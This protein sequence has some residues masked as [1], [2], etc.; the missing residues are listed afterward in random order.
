MLLNDLNGLGRIEVTTIP[1]PDSV[2]VLTAAYTYSGSVLVTCRRKEDPDEADYYTLAVMN[3]D[4]TGFHVIFSGQIPQKKGA[5]GIRFMPFADKTRVLLG[6][7]VLECSPDIDSCMK[8]SLIPLEYP[9]GIAE[10]PKTM[11]HWSEIIIAPDNQHI[12]WTS[13]RSDNGAAAFTGKLVRKEDRYIIEKT[14]LISSGCFLKEEGGYLIPQPIRGGEVKQFVRGGTAISSVGAK[15]GSLA[16]SVIQELLSEEVAQITHTPGYDE[17][18]MLSPDE[19]LGL[20]MSAR[21]SKGTSCAVFG[22]LPKPYGAYTSP[23][24]IMPVYMYC[25]AGVRAFRR[26]NIGPILIDINRS[27][28]ERDYMGV[29]LCDPEEK[30]VY[31]SPMSWHPDSKRVMWPEILRESLSDEK[32]APLRIRMA[33]LLDYVPADTVPA[34]GTPDIIPYAGTYEDYKALSNQEVTGRIQGKSCGYMEVSQKGSSMAGGSAET[35]Y[36]NFSDDGKTFWN[37]KEELTYGYQKE[38]VYRADLELSGREQGEMKLQA[39]FSAMGQGPV[40]LLFDPDENGKPKS[41]GYSSYRGI[42]WKI[43]DM[44]K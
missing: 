34:A 13:L 25:V 22:L 20:V 7:Y 30:W 33:R 42:T 24:L 6:D 31:C 12:S 14:N 2:T 29:N 18:T 43:E 32:P 5:N 40:R 41:R 23:G 37:G 21:G 8:A 28:E 17:T 11:A 27:M 1:M 38:T 35:V 10:D 9:W 36:V 15:E 16:D 44:E 26:G 39:V 4:G 3:D 19:R